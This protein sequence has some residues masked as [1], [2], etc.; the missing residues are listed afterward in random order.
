MSNRAVAI[1]DEL[2]R[3]VRNFVLRR[4]LKGEEISVKEVV[5]ESLTEHL[6][7]VEKKNGSSDSK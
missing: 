3:R 4:Q 5:E 7:K 6:D 2:W 1:S